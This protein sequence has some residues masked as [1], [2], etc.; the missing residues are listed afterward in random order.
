MKKLPKLVKP[1]YTI[2]ET[3][4][5]L[6]LAG[7]Y[8]DKVD[9]ILLL[10]SEGQIKVS[11]LLDRSVVLIKSSYATPYLFKKGLDVYPSEDE[12]DSMINQLSDSENKVRP[13][14]RRLIHSGLMIPNFLIDGDLYEVVDDIELKFGIPEKPGIELA[15]DALQSIEKE[16]DNG[17]L[18]SIRSIEERQIVIDPMR[19]RKDH[20]LNRYFEPQEMNFWGIPMWESLSDLHALRWEGEVYYVCQEIHRDYLS[21]MMDY[22]VKLK[23]GTVYNPTYVLDAG[24]VRDLINRRN[25]V[26]SKN[27]IENFEA[28]H[29][30]IE[31][32]VILKD[33]PAY[34][35]PNNKYYA[36]E[37]SIAIE[38]HTAIF[39]NNEG[40]PNRPPGARVKRWLSEHY[41]D[42]KG[43]F[44]DRISTVVLPK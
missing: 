20:S 14:I 24:T 25:H 31:H 11:L 30:G 17:A 29:L 33:T 38:A 28:E 16:I 12:V 10:A 41:P 3:F 7:A 34:L 13:E 9:D 44:Y 37:L 35:D 15:L 42:G 27:T 22:N 6:K 23:D 43:N 32:G 36:K 39:I 1:Y 4:N 2:D 5:R 8:L 40:N 19:V 26:I 21:E 18:D